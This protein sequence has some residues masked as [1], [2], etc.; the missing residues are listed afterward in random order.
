MEMLRLEFVNCSGLSQVKG[1]G[2]LELL[3]VLKSCGGSFLR[4][5]YGAIDKNPSRKIDEKGSILGVVGI[6]HELLA[7]GRFHYAPIK[8]PPHQ[9]GTGSVS[10]IHDYRD[11]R[12]K[13]HIEE[14][15]IEHLDAIA[16]GLTTF[17]RMIYPRL[18]PSYGWIDES[19]YV[20]PTDVIRKGEPRFL[21]WANI[22]GPKLVQ[23]I[24]LEF[25]LEAPGWKKEKLDDGGLLFVVESQ[26]LHFL[27]NPMGSDVSW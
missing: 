25:V 12:L 26:Y 5:A 7:K 17:A 6:E 4:T 8:V 3:D 20:E 27:T 9:H 16:N 14:N 19:G 11:F 21:S 2:A 10:Y 13:Q 15:D 18:R 1:N 22:F 23:H 24:G